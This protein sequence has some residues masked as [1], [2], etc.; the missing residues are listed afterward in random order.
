MKGS[1]LCVATMAILV[2]AAVTTTGCSS[3]A[4]RDTKALSISQSADGKGIEIAVSEGL[5]RSVLEQAIGAE[6]ECG[7][8][9]DDDFGRL[10][11]ELDRGGRH[12]RGTLRDDDGVVT[13]TRSGSKLRMK[14]DTVDDDGRFE[15]TMP[16]A[17]AECLLDGSAR[18]TDRDVGRIKVRV[19]GGEGGS[20]ELAVK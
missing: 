11:R 17:V 14:F 4:P 19:I 2:G 13:A 16:W 3:S 7:A 8:E 1:H 18:L 9:L 5:A 20:F 15:V 12:S 6:I 10:L